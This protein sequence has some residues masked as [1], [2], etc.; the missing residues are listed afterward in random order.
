MRP[1]TKYID[2]VSGREFKTSQEARR[3]ETKYRAIAE[4]FSW[5]PDMCKLTRAKSDSSCDFENGYW[6]VQWSK[7]ERD[8]LV[9][10]IYR[11]I[12]RWERWLVKGWDVSVNG[13]FE[14]KHIY[15]YYVGRSLGDGS[16]A[17]YKYYS[18]LT[19]I[20]PKCYR[21][22]GQPYFAYNCH[23]DGTAGKD[24]ERKPIPVRLMKHATE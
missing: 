7:E 17:L 19:E 1:T 13:P 18:L 3:S 12:K 4:L 14:R 2:E 8:R 21:G 11:A 6:C 24:H 5:V 22:Y 23:C 10:C 9:D 20:C 16:S 15:T